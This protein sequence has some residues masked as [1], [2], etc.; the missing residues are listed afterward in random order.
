M[1]ET[2]LTDARRYTTDRLTLRTTFGAL[3]RN[4]GLQALLGY[5]LGKFLALL[6]RDYR[7]AALAAPGWLLYLPLRTYARFALGIRLDL[8]ADIGPGLYIGHLGNIHLRRCK[9]GL[10]CSIAQSSQIMPSADGAGPGIGSHVWIGAHARI[11]GPFTIGSSATISAGAVVFRN[12]PA[13]ALCLGNP[14]RIVIRHYD[15]SRLLSTGLARD[16]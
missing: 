4:Y 3:C 6:T 1:M 9:L 12:I 14:A 8:S 7:F 15:N 11:I 16:A 5:R 13:G 2:F 10:N